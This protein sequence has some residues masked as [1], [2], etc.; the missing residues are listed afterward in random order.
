MNLKTVRWILGAIITLGVAV[1]TEM[2]GSTL[3]PPMAEAQRKGTIT[4]WMIT[5][6]MVWGTV[7]LAVVV[8]G[9]LVVTGLSKGHAQE[10]HV[11]ARRP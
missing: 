9:F 2:I 4:P 3:L 6:G 7:A 10:P 8:A 11:A 1:V 5:W